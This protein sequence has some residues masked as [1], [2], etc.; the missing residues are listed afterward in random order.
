MDENLEQVIARRVKEAEW[1][2]K[3]E[4]RVTNLEDVTKE[5]KKNV[6]SIN[7]AVLGLTFSVILFIITI[8]A[9]LIGGY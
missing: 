8:A 1:K 4:E 3:I 5:I 6:E 7:R 9:K 2:T